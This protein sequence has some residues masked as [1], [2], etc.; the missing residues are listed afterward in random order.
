MPNYTP[1]QETILSDDCVWCNKPINTEHD[2]GFT[3]FPFWVDGYFATHRAYIHDDEINGFLNH[4]HNCF[5]C[6]DDNEAF[7]Q[8]KGLRQ[9]LRS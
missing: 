5:D 9:H 1:R 2:I 7:G 3:S 4:I 6:F 8:Y